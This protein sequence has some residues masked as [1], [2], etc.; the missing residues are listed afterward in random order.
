[1]SSL[2]YTA[3]E[4]AEALGI[5][6]TSLYAYV[7]R[8]R[9]RTRPVPGS[10]AN[11]YWHEDIN[12]LAHRSRGAADPEPGVSL[13]PTTAITLLTREGPYYRG[14]SAIVMAETETLEAAAGHLWQVDPETI[15]TPDA[16]FDLPDFGPSVSGL[17]AID[18][19]MS[20]LP[21]LQAKD[22]R[23]HDLSSSGAARSGARILRAF[24]AVLTGASEVDDAPMHEV[25]ARNAG[26]DPA[27]CDIVRRLLVLTLDHELTPATYAVRAAANAG[28]TPYQ[29]VGVGLTA[30]IGR[31]N[32]AGRTYAVR[33]LIEEILD[34]ADPT[35]PVIARSRSGELLPGFHGGAYVGEDVR[36]TALLKALEAAFGDDPDLR[37]L[38]KGLDA[39]RQAYGSEPDLVVP[40]VFIEG[41]LGLRDTD[42]ALGVVGRLAGWI[43]HAQEQ[44]ESSGLLRFGAEYT[45]PLPQD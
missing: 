23:G 24:A 14:R 33:R 2:Y 39:A 16:A 35:S 21:V 28:I 4:A 42:G 8:K 44:F 27:W 37:R 6:V 20:L 45:G 41:K 15:F 19:M 22:P 32:L 1:M 17:G 5:S 40:S 36:A 34:A 29:A 26:A 13:A 12:R 31:R 38:T 9:I 7:S 3:E 18:R 30:N 25:I 10:K 43:A 11:L